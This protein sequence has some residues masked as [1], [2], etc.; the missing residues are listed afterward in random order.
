METPEACQP[1]KEKNQ[2]KQNMKLLPSFIA[3]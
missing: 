1:F 2:Q 3:K